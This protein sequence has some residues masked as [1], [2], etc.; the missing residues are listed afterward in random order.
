MRKGLEMNSLTAYCAISNKNAIVKDS[1]TCIAV[2]N[3]SQYDTIKNIAALFVSDLFAYYAVNTFSSIGI[4]REQTQSDNKYSLP[5]LNISAKSNIGNIEQAIQKI[6]SEKQ[7]ALV[8]AIKIQELQNSIQEEFSNL[9]EKIYK[10]LNLSDI[11]SSILDY[12]LN[13]SRKLIVNDEAEST[14]IFSAIKFEDL[15]LKKYAAIFLKRFKS[16]LDTKEKKFVIEIW[17]TNQIVGMFFK[18]IPVSKYS[19]S[20]VWVNKQNS[21]SEVLSFLTKISSEKI[22]DKLFVQKDIRGFEKDYFYIF[23]P[24]EKRLWHPAISYLDVNEFA[25]AI[26]KSE[27]K[28]K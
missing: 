18:M 12:S 1:V 25:D 27:N 10:N 21:D 11:E 24:N 3:K 7:K 4:E 16:K 9:N 17:H 28:R 19:K 22:T 20:I 6:Y 14:R 8:N 13:V 26:L 15:I 23:K 2:L 5:Y